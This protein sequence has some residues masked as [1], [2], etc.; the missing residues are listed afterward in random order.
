MSEEINIVD[1]PIVMYVKEHTLELDGSFVTELMEHNN[2]P[3]KIYTDENL[4]GC[5]L[6]KISQN[7]QTLEDIGE[8]EKDTKRLFRST[9][10]DQEENKRA[11]WVFL[12]NL[13]EKKEISGVGVV[14]LYGG[15]L[16]AY[17][18][19]ETLTIIPNVTRRDDCKIEELGELKG[20]FSNN[21]T[22]FTPVDTKELNLSSK[23]IDLT[24]YTL[25][26]NFSD[27]PKPLDEQI[28]L[29]IPEQVVL[30]EKEIEIPDSSFELSNETIKLTDVTLSLSSYDE[31]NGYYHYSSLISSKNLKEKLETTLPDTSIELSGNIICKFSEEDFGNY[32]I[33]INLIIAANENEESFSYFYSQRDTEI[34][35]K[36]I[37]FEEQEASLEDILSTETADDYINVYTLKNG[38]KYYVDTYNSSG[39]NEIRIGVI[40]Q[41]GGQTKYATNGVS[42]NIIRSI[43]SYTWYTPAVITKQCYFGQPCYNNENTK[44]IEFKQSDF[45]ESKGNYLPKDTS[46]VYINNRVKDSLLGS[47]LEGSE[48][49]KKIYNLEVYRWSPGEAEFKLYSDFLIGDKNL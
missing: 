49:Y 35:F 41:V 9:G 44:I 2:Y 18:Y 3:I 24:T 31:E 25:T 42:L 30:K 10:N 12:E 15:I 27:L 36:N 29:I 14:S 13:N 26:S 45:D 6:V 8:L 5:K 17:D 48:V 20:Y 4:D 47:E 7:K 39:L 46:F 34:E 37:T 21:Y 38:G 16:K 19:E 23:N 43:E 11:W 33:E 32:S 40:K 28:E 1:T 22:V